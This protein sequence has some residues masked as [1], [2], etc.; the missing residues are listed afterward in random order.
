MKNIIDD[1]RLIADFMGVRSI[2]YGV[3]GL[4]YYID[5][6]PYQI[7]KLKYHSSW[8]WLMHVV[9][10]IHRTN[11]ADIVMHSKN[12]VEIS[13]GGE[14]KSYYSSSEI[15]NVFEACVDFIKWHNKQNNE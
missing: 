7:F 11:L 12:L 6:I 2:R 9:I 5:N 10:K 1:N 13:Y 4:I 14:T 8:D 15:M 3:S